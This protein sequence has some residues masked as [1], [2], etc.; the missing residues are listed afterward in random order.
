[1]NARKPKFHDHI[2][3]VRG[4]WYGHYRAICTNYRG[5]R[6]EVSFTNSQIWDAWEDENDPFYQ[7]AHRIVYSMITQAYHEQNQIWKS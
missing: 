6:V 4:T 2:Y 5:K 3:L 7:D 1:M